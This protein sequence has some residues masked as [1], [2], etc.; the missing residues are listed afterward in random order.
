MHFQEVCYIYYYG[1]RHWN[2]EI[3]VLYSYSVYF[4]NKYSIYFTE[5]SY[6][7]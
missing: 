3:C 7:L 5:Y 6:N 1:F 2:F 4:Q